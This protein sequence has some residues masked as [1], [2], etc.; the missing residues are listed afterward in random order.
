M[1]QD[2][3][4]YYGVFHGPPSHFCVFFLFALARSIAGH[5]QKKNTEIVAAEMNNFLCFIFVF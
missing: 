2:S 4:T 1:C 5:I 3:D